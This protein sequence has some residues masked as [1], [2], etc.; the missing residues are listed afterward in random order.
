MNGL[1]RVFLVLLRL[2]IGWHF[3]F[4]GVEKVH[5]VMTGPTE[6]NRPWTSEGY[7][8]E[9]S[10]PFADQLRS[11]FGDPDE[12]A[13]ARLRVEPVVAGQDPSRV[14]A[15]SRI[16]PALAQDWQVY[17]D[18][19]VA[20]H[21]LDDE[22]RLLAQAKLDQSKE[23]AVLWLLGQRGAQ[24][25]RRTYPTG[26]V[27]V[28]ETP[29]QRIEYYRT[30]LEQ[31]RDL[32]AR[33]MPSFERDVA[34]GRLRALKNEVARV[35][36]D[37]LSD[38]NR[39]MRE[40]L[41]SVLTDAQKKATLPE[42]APAPWLA[43][44]R[45]DWVRWYSY[46]GL[47]VVG[48]CLLV[49][50]VA[51]V[52]A[53]QSRS[54]NRLGGSEWALVALLTIA[55]A[56][57]LA[58]FL[59]WI[60]R[61]GADMDWATRGMWARNWLLATIAGVILLGLVAQLVCRSREAAEWT[62]AQFWAASALV[63]VGAGLA[64]GLAQLTAVRWAGWTNQQ[65]ADW[66]VAFGLT[67]VGTC[68]LL[69]FLT[70][71]ACVAGAVLLLLFYLAMPPFPGVPDNPRAEGHYLFINK[72]VIEMLALLALAT[73]ASGR[74]LGLD[75]LI[76]ALNPVRWFQRRTDTPESPSPLRRRIAHGH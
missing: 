5:S 25:V 26:T 18:R 12:A 24:G 57:G 53:T 10:G 1:T 55:V 66:L 2:A 59:A 70:R 52:V 4:E 33:E 27:E 74:W 45:A 37:L 75:A 17:F 47:I 7:L 42:V 21:Q 35:R 20:H 6:T 58:A 14:S 9:S 49:G 34:K 73:T 29:P 43:W 46:W 69:G 3:L 76:R 15:A 56:A 40:A 67:A 22:Q 63:V 13:L 61:Q 31:L 68:L 38:L 32:E 62:W 44:D 11:Q 71:P 41:D 39:P 36:N 54:I 16:P 64:L 23:N 72:N 28:K 30:K 19:F 50:G 51:Q 8:R 48:T 60:V 65:L